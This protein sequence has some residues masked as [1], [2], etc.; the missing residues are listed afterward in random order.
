MS[1]YIIT[2][3]NN[4]TTHLLTDHIYIEGYNEREILSV[5]NNISYPVYRRVRILHVSDFYHSILFHTSIYII[6]YH[7][8]FTTHLGSTL[9]GILSCGSWISIKDKGSSDYYDEVL[10]DEWDTFLVFEFISAA[11]SYLASHLGSRGGWGERQQWLLRQVLRRSTLDEVLY[12]EWDTFFVVLEFIS[13]ATSYLAVHL[14][15]R[16]DGVKGSS[17]YYDKVLYDKWDT[18]WWFLNSY[19]G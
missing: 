3:H 15:S 18:F 2:H 16:G 1:A 19:Q 14:G 13:A 17:D 7:P 4:L 5:W 8:N 11:T 12:D 10:Y 9:S 6:T